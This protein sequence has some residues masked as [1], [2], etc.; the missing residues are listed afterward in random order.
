MTRHRSAD[1]HPLLG[2]KISTAATPENQQHTRNHESSLTS[3]PG[4]GSFDVLRLFV[5]YDLF[6]FFMPRPW[7]LV[8]SRARLWTIQYWPQRIKM[9]D[10][11]CWSASLLALGVAISGSYDIEPLGDGWT[12]KSNP[13][14]YYIRLH[15]SNMLFGARNISN[16]SHNTST[17]ASMLSTAITEMRQD[18]NMFCNASQHR[19]LPVV[20]RKWNDVQYDGVTLEHGATSLS[21]SNINSFRISYLMPAG[22]YPWLCLFWIFLVSFWFQ[23]HRWGRNRY[24]SASQVVP[25]PD[26]HTTTHTDSAHTPHQ[27]IP[28]SPFDYLIKIVLLQATPVYGLEYDIQ[29]PDFWRWVEYALTSPIQIL[30]IANS[31]LIFDRGKLL[32]LISSQAAL[33]MLGHINEQLIDKVYKKM[34][35][36]WR[37][38]SK[39]KITWQQQRGNLFLKL[40]ITLLVSWFVF[41]GIWWP[42][43]SAFERQARNTHE[44]DYP[45]PMPDAIWF[46]VG[47][48]LGLFTL[49]GLVQTVQYIQLLGLEAD[50][51]KFETLL[52]EQ[53]DEDLADAGV[54]KT[55]WWDHKN[56]I[57]ITDAAKA[58]RREQEHEQHVDS[59]H[60]SKLVA[61]AGD[62]SQHVTVY[63]ERRRAQSWQNTALAYS[64][65]SITAKTLLEWGFI[66]LVFFGADMH[67]QS[68]A[69][70]Q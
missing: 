67:T 36:W 28:Q 6:L 5:L 4:V 46:I 57:L 31:V 11:L 52:F 35:K 14:S 43:V 53:A 12:T 65:L 17:P 66:W 54:K 38:R 51:R 22:F 9:I 61:L 58:E 45:E 26:T 56:Q 48:Q 62:Q 40:R 70:G 33:V 18:V 24:M 8:G 68:N 29:K 42:I 34:N 59:T 39:S 1:L 55:L 20:Y 25:Q 41:W 49:F 50:L 16:H 13:L 60:K 3:K 10:L 63:C 15:D 19:D 44:C 7:A 32:A 27:H 47:T 23:L 30:L 2:V 21:E 37:H 64:I 69:S